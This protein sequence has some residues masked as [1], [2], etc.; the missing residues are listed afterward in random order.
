MYKKIVMG[1]LVALAFV[2][3]YSLHNAGA[4]NPYADNATLLKKSSARLDFDYSIP[5]VVLCRSGNYTTD[6]TEYNGTTIRMVPIPEGAMILDV[7]VYTD[8]FGWDGN[9]TWSVGDDDDND[10]FFVAYNATNCLNKSF[11]VNSTSAEFG[12]GFMYVYPESDT[13]DLQLEQVGSNTAA[14]QIPSGKELRLDVKYKM[15]LGHDEK[16]ENNY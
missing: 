13:I 8:G 16:T 1:C 5:G 2:C 10:R 9:F 3:A 4:A 11:I 6:G 14:D 7:S 15:V 12:S